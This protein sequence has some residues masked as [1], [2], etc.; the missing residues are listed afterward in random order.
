MKIRSFL[1]QGR[2][3]ERSW[4]CKSV[5]IRVCVFQRERSQVQD[6][7]SSVSSPFWRSLGRELRHT[8][9]NKRKRGAAISGENFKTKSQALRGVLVK[10]N[11]RLF[12]L[13]PEANFFT[14]TESCSFTLYIFRGTLWPHFTFTLFTL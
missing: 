13:W 4:S 7:S 3:S 1:F 8:Q 12:E 10:N 14:C 6:S 11:D 5:C 9:R 2:A